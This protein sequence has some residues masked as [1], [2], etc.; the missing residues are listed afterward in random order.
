M[1]SDP[2][3]I[4][5]VSLSAHSTISPSG[6]DSFATTD[7]AP[8]RTVRQCSISAITGGPATLTISHSVSNDNKPAKTDR[9]LLRLDFLV[10]DSSGR[11]MNAYAY[12]VVG[13]PRGAYYYNDGTQALSGVAVAQMLIGAL[14]GVT[15]SALDEARITRVLAGEP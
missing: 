11:E 8:G 5:G 12:A 14:C 4:K 2:L 10:K 7:V 9:S 1:L 6:V 15:A 3:T 13:I